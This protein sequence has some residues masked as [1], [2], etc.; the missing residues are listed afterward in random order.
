[1]TIL[2][3]FSDHQNNEVQSDVAKLQ[4]A[5][6]EMDAHTA[7]L[8]NEALRDFNIDAS[9]VDW[10][11]GPTVTLFK[12]DI[13]PGVRV[14]KIE[15][16]TD[17]LARTLTA[18]SIRMLCPVPGTKYVGLEVPHI[19]EYN[20]IPL[21]QNTLAN[22]PEGLMQIPIGIDVNGD[23]VFDD[24]TEM[25]HLIIGGG[26]GSGTGV[27]IEGMLY[28]LL[29]HKESANIEL[30]L[31][32]PLRVNFT[33]Y[34]DIPHLIAPVIV[35]PEDAARALSWAANEMERRL[36][37]LAS[38]GVRTIEQYNNYVVDEMVAKENSGEETDAG[39]DRL[40]H[41][42]IAINDLANL[43]LSQGPASLIEQ[44]I[45]RIALLGKAA[46]IHLILSTAKLGTSVLTGP[47]KANIPHRIAFG[48]TGSLESRVILDTAGAEKLVGNGDLLYSKPD[49]P[50]PVRLQGFFI[51][52]NETKQL[53]G[54][55]REEHGPRYRDEILQTEI[56]EIKPLKNFEKEPEPEEDPLLWHAAKL[57]VDTGLGSYANI[58]R[59]L[60]VGYSRANRIIDSL[61][62]LG[63]V[64][65]P[66]ESRPRDVLIDAT[67]L[68]ELRTKMLFEQVSPKAS[69]TE[70]QTF[71]N[72]IVGPSNYMAYAMARCVAENPG[73][74]FLNPVFIY[75]PPS[76]GKTHLLCAIKNYVAT[77]KPDQKVISLDAN[78]FV[79]DY[80]N[81]ALRGGDNKKEFKEKYL[82][83]SILM[84]S[85]VQML[86]GMNE[87]LSILFQILRILVDQGC[88]VVFTADRRPWHIDID[89]RYTAR[90]VSGII[91][92]IQ[93]PE[94]EVRLSFANQYIKVLRHKLAEVS[95]HDWHIQPEVC[96]AIAGRLTNMAYIKGA[97]GMFAF[98]AAKR[99]DSYLTMPYV[100]KVLSEFPQAHATSEPSNNTARG[101]SW[102]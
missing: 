15:N 89:K 56:P 13:A 86:Q 19:K 77:H 71:K 72:F 21:L 57:V 51:S 40:T 6:Q 76:C 55:L 7:D 34:K 25:P 59:H 3:S 81:A 85:N 43:M 83:A 45:A 50:K 53:T 84:I 73:E 97:L 35:N 41:I 75:G 37:A 1:M 5:L 78:D 64:G 33:V 94:Y 17:D 95:K 42:V 46:G 11:H 98:Q 90:F 26:P 48:T 38:A 69:A 93:P 82:Q 29:S 24:L 92:P 39:I 87:T 20:Q 96:H 27:F 16:F 30:I 66:N 68:D 63:V 67:E 12:L 74:P 28:A 88:Q 47:M 14:S 58:Q 65:P 70:K 10:I 49:Y 36:K 91:C 22:R 4:D 62:K 61:E 52:R 79:A 100:N 80:C 102:T 2:K 32:D 18:P 44:S 101:T 99:G 31:I 9:V 23:T 8:I 54:A 60:Q